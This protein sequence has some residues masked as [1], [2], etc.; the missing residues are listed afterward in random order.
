M[1]DRFAPRLILHG[2]GLT[3]TSRANHLPSAKFIPLVH[4]KRVEGTSRTEET[5]RRVK[6]KQ[7]GFDH[8]RQALGDPFDGA[9]R[10]TVLR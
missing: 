9:E 1:A 2:Y 4:D 8:W 6:P 3:M 5:L 7:G 10:K